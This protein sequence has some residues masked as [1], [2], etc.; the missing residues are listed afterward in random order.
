MIFKAKNE[1]GNTGVISGVSGIETWVNNF[2]KNFQPQQR[3]NEKDTQ[4]INNYVAKLDELKAKTATMSGTFHQA[5]LES[6]AWKSTMQDQSEEAQTFVRGLQNGTE[7]LGNMTKASKA[8]ELGMKALAMAGNMLVS[9]LIGSFISVA[10]EVANASNE[11]ADSAQQIGS[12]FKETTSDLDDYQIKVE[13]LQETI[14][15]SSSSISDVRDARKELM[16][17]QDELIEKYGTEEDSVKRITDAVNGEADAWDKL[18]KKKW[19]QAKN[20]FND[21]GKD[22]ILKGLGRNIVIYLGMYFS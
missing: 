21:T 5:N 16:S 2:K 8:S 14:N 9:F 19:T 11:I 10:F 13:D 12:S 4:A 20:E 6:M 18:K 1:W 3:F 7:N 15:D 17:I 22:G